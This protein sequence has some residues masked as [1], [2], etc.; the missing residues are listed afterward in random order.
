MKT[1]PETCAMEDMECCPPICN[2]AQCCFCCFLCTVDQ[3][4]P[5]IN[6]YHTTI[7]SSSSEKQYALSDFES[8]CWQPPETV[9]FDSRLA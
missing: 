6:I 8:D 3:K 9:T 4:K 2:P 5:G 7:K 1:D